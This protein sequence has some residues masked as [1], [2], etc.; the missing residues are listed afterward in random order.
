MAL[1]EEERD[2]ILQ[3]AARQGRV[4]V[5][6]FEIVHRFP[7]E[8]VVDFGMDALAITLDGGLTLTMTTPPPVVTGIEIVPGTPVHN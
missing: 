7:D 3:D 1:S 5:Q 8:L 6:V 2:Q 4:Q